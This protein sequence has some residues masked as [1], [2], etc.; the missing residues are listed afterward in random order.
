[1]LPPQNQPEPNAD[2]EQNGK[3]DEGVEEGG[4]DLT[5]T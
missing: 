5:P 4:H 3:D 1:M 2:Q